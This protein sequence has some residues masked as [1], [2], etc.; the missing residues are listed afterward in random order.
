MSYYK[1]GTRRVLKKE[2]TTLLKQKLVKSQA[3]KPRWTEHIAHWTPR[4]DIGKDGRAQKNI[5]KT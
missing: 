1:K 3:D 5:W 2:S 4:R